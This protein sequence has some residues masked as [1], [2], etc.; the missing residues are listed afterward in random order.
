MGLSA[1]ADN[2]TNNLSNLKLN[3]DGATPVN[4]PQFAGNPSAIA[5]NF[6]LGFYTYKEKMHLGFFNTAFARQ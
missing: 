3:P 1:G 2:Q 4:D 6:G 5:A